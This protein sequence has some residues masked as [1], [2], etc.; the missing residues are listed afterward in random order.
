VIYE[1]EEE[2]SDFDDDM[3]VWN[4]IEQQHVFFSDIVGIS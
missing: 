1:E 4:S 3:E 2:E